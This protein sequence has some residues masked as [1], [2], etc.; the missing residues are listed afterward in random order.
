MTAVRSELIAM[1][2]AWHF[3]AL[4]EQREGHSIRLSNCKGQVG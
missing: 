4:S 2:P 1:M 3:E